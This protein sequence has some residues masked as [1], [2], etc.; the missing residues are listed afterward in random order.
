[1]IPNSRRCP[2][3]MLVLVCISVTVQAAGL[4]V[5]VPAYFGSS[6]PDWKRLADAAQRV[7]LVA[8]ANVDNGPGTARDPAVA[9]VIQRVQAQGG[10]VTG[11][12][13]SQYAARPLAVVEADL[14]HW[15]EWYG[16]DGVFIDEMDNQPLTAHLDYYAELR[17]FAISLNPQWHV[18][19]NP[20]IN[21]AEAYVTRATADTLVVF[22]N[23]TGYLKN[24]PDS[25]NH[26]YPPPT[27]CHLLYT[28]TNFTT[29]TNFLGTAVSRGAGFVYVTDDGADGNPWDRLPKFWDE[30]LLWIEAWNKTAARQQ[31][32]TVTI[33]RAGDAPSPLTV[34]VIGSVGRYVLESS[35]PLGSWQALVTNLT[36]NGRLQWPLVPGE[37]RANRFYR[38]RQD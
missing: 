4:A 8:I 38:I 29:A 22:E 13:F 27:F 36:T 16:L 20:G 11:Y 24:R 25:W 37:L 26:R 14:R 5:M 23:D 21:T 6:S 35:S 18:T 28:V 2:L 9:R 30:E 15:S 10:Q 3:A 19:G 34:G 32:A 1:M 31:L 12:V 17:R 7:P 33:Q